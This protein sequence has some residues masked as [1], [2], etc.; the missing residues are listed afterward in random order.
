MA[1]HLNL[2]CLLD[3]K[4]WVQRGP[5]STVWNG[6]R[7][8]AATDFNKA[9]AKDV[10]HYSDDGLRVVLYKRAYCAGIDSL[11]HALAKGRL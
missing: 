11:F 5:A 1:G 10:P 2:K 4:R 3:Y 7:F 8:G 6:L 9:K